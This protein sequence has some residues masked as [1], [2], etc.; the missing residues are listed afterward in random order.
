[1]SGHYSCD[2]E[3]KIIRVILCPVSAVYDLDDNHRYLDKEIGREV[4]GWM[5]S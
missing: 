1:M 3:Q 4:Y 2:F 5:D